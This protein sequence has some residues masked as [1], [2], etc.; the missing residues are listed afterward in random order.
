MKTKEVVEAISNRINVPV[1]TVSA[2][3][4]AFTDVIKEGLTLGK[5]VDLKS[6]GTF[7]AKTVKRKISF[8][9]P[10]TIRTRVGFTSSKSVSLGQ[11]ASPPNG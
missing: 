3:L 11:E 5:E 2:V 1:A 8:G 4:T 6:F 7:Y 10:T 9:K